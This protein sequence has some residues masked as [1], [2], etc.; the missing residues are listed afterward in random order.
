MSLDLSLS[1]N[2]SQFEV[3]A[4]QALF[5]EKRIRVKVGELNLQPLLYKISAG[6][7]APPRKLFACIYTRLKLDKGHAYLSGST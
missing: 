3:G 7:T 4:S 2:G 1:E 5:G 6:T